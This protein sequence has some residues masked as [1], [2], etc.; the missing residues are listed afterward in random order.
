MNLLKQLYNLLPKTLQD[1]L[2]V[3][4]S[5]N[6]QESPQ[7]VYNILP[8]QI[9]NKFNISY[10]QRLENGF[11]I[12][13]T[14]NE[15]W[16]VLDKNNGLLIRPIYESIG[17]SSS[18]KWFVCT[19]FNGKN[20]NRW[21]YFMYDLNG[22]LLCQNSDFSSIQVDDFGNVICCIR[23]RIDNKSNIQYGL[24]DD[25]LVVNFAPKYNII[26]SLSATKFKVRQNYKWG[27]IDQND[28][29]ILNINYQHIHGNFNY[30]T[31]FVENDN[32]TFQV[33]IDGNIVKKLP[34][35]HFFY[36]KSNTYGAPNKNDRLTKLKTFIGKKGENAD[37]DEMDE[38]I[39]KWGVIDL[40]GEVIVEAKYDF[41]DF[42]QSPN[43]FK[44]IVG[45]ID[46]NWEDEEA[47][48]YEMNGGKC[49]VIGLNQQV[50][51][52][53]K[54]NWIEE[55]SDNLFAVNLGGQVYYDDEY[56]CNYWDVKGGKWGV[57]NH[58]S[59]LIIPVEYDAIMLSWFRVK[60]Y[61][62]VQNGATYFDEK[63]NYTVYDFDG[64]KI[65]KHKPKPK[66]HRYYNT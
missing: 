14:K 21:S 13:K 39:G 9:K 10:S 37:Y 27:I 44:I 31:V 60:D 65:T 51:I 45:K 18:K 54:Y 46:Y 42:F 38:Y 26:T 15:K 32:E 48:E 63:L 28:H 6:T 24:L 19:N 55:I 7:Q 36:P 3:K 35:T 66:N 23:N 2:E 59:K 12:V 4:Q 49:G 25:N 11:T 5:Q 47:D 40:S 53:P 50:I 58:Q 30:K 8:Q 22:Q 16:A 52:P 33:D 34:Y 17:F 61:I 57:I 43:Y 64:N 1:K 41:V 62:F 29:I 56:Q 20:S